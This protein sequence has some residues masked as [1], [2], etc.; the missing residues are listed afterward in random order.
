M[1]GMKA[2][3]VF[4]IASVFDLAAGSSTIKA[5]YERVRF[6]VFVASSDVRS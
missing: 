5:V 2:L 1:A 4:L 3:L 6:V